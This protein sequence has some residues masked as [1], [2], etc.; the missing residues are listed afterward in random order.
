MM[1]SSLAR[2]TVALL[3]FCG[4][5]GAA[6]AQLASTRLYFGVGREIPIEV[7]VPEGKEGEAVIELLRPITA[8]KAGTASVLPGKVNL[9]TLFPTLWNTKT[10]TL[11]Y[12]QLSVGGEKIGPALVLQPLV[13][14]KS[15]Q[16]G[17][18][19]VRFVDG[20]NVYSGLRIYTDKHVVFET[21]KGEIEFQL[22]PDAAPNTAFN[23]RHLVEGG[24]YTD[25]IFHRIVPKLPS[26]EPFVIQVGDPTAS[27]SGGP[28]YQVDLEQSTLPHDFGVLSNARSGDPNSNGSQVFVCLSRNGTSFLDGQYTSFAQATRGGDV[29][30]A[31]AA[32]PT[33]PGD[34]PLD[35]M[36]KIK[37]AKLV[38]APP[39]AG[40]IKMVDAGVKKDEIETNK[41][42][43]R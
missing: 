38:D 23:F 34:R 10:P 14:P 8:E 9:A 4:L 37:S 1:N 15:A 22:R 20:P 25:I 12:A 36:P 11:L 32:S 41:P 39:F 27:G 24:F 3:A 5:A 16:G 42:A 18:G 33:G 7:K 35:P 19:G 28:G 43:E 40:S 26:G 13:S 31:I 21:D 30:R 17:P 29:I 2:S 6:H